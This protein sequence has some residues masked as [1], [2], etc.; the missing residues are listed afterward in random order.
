MV[1]APLSA[2][3]QSL[4]P[5]ST[6]KLGPSGAASQVV[7]TFQDPVGLSSKLSC[8][9]GS[10]SQCCLNPHRCYQSEGLRLQF[11]VLES[12]VSRSVLLTSCSSRF[13]CMRMWDQLVHRLPPCRR[14]LFTRLPVS[15]PPTG[16]GECFSVSSSSAWLSDFHTVQFSVSSGCFLFLNCCPSFGCARRHSVSTYASIFLIS[17][18]KA[19]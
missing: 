19:R 1:L 4:P 11:P 13:I 5:L 16:L 9:A 14:V 18:F 15:A 12:W 10:F 7:C 8:E 2:G 3:F 17:I 6:I